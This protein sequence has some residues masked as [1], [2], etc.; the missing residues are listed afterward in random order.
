MSSRTLVRSN[1]CFINS[2]V[3]H[4]TMCL[5]RFVTNFRL[6]LK[7]RMLVLTKRPRSVPI[8]SRESNGL[9]R[10]NV[11]STELYHIYMFLSRWR[12]A[13]KLVLP[14]E[15][16]VTRRSMLEYAQALRPRY[17]KASQEEKTRMLDEFTEVTGLHCKAAIRILNRVS[18]PTLNKRRGRKRRYGSEVGEALKAIWEARDQPLRLCPKLARRRSLGT[19]NP[20]SLLESL[21]P[22]KI[23]TERHKNRFGLLEV[24]LVARCGRRTQGFYLIT[25]STVDAGNDWS[26]AFGRRG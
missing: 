7:V 24:D 18:H 13:S 5:L 8:R 14:K 6:V 17:Q 26:L 2:L 15:V 3:A 20:R 23:F 4:L 9:C 16:E 11:H 10:T 21:T 22:I 25:R 19:T 12:I 1:P